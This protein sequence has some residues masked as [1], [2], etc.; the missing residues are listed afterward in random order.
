MTSIIV[1]PT[2]SGKTGYIQN[3]S[4]ENLEN[5]K[6][7]FIVLR[8]ITA[9]LI[10][11]CK[12]WSYNLNLNTFDRNTNKPSVY[13]CLSNIHQ[14]S[15]MYCTIDRINHNFIIILDE[16]DLIYLDKYDCKQSTILFEEMYKN[17]NLEHKYY[18]T[19]TPF[20]LFKHVPNLLCS[21]IYR[22][23]IKDTYIGFDKIKKWHILG[24]CIQRMTK[25]DK[26]EDYS[27]KY[28]ELLK[29][30][31][32]RNSH[33]VILFNCTSLILLQERIGKEF[34]KNFNI[35]V[36]IDH[37]EY[38]RLYTKCKIPGLNFNENCMCDLK[39][40]HI[41]DLLKL[42]KRYD[43]GTKVVIV[44]GIKA[45]RGQSYKTEDEN[46][47]H[48]TDLVYMPPKSQTCETLI[49]ACGRITG[50]Y[51]NSHK[52][53]HIWTTKKAK[54][55]VKSYMEYQTKILEESSKHSGKIT[56]VIEKTTY[57]GYFKLV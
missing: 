5:G 23:Q 43:N 24:N 28:I 19:A 56:E 8:N 38:T 4:C 22:L 49:Q 21:N 52:T 6:S 14:L 27:S 2:Q 50:I 18:V 20:S 31:L 42:L 33:Q 10:Q 11:F 12:R 25:T 26:F 57:T 46:E 40:Q 36:V 54:E 51:S 15:K 13:I 37:G 44:S 29:Y 47:W 3:L 55:S 35:N 53:L 1:S 32:E 7:V 34:F 45:G 30:I 41:K 17:C 39:K 48:L 16:A 9:D